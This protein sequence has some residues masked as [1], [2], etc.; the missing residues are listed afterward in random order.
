MLCVVA[1]S[2][3]RRGALESQLQNI[4]RSMHSMPPAHGALLVERVLA[5]PAL[6]EAWQAE[7]VEMAARLQALRAKLARE[8]AQLRPDLD[9]GWLTRQQGMFS[10]LGI[11]PQEVCLLRERDHVYLVGDSRINIAG[12]N[13]DNLVA[14]A[15]AVAPMLR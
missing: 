6:R 7:I 3:Q 14:V 8:I 5:E 12:L 9:L 11:G 1:G 10:L 4:A 2:A 15:R 13:E